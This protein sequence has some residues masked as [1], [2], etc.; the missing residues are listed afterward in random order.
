MFKE[1]FKYYKSK[2]PPPNL[3]EVIDFSNI[4]NAVDKVKRII[5]SNNNVPTKRFLE[6]GLKEANQWDVF[7]LDERPGLRFVRNPFLPIGQRY[8]IKRCLEN[9]TSKPNQLNLDTLGV[10][11]SDENWWTSCQSNNIQSSELLHKLRWATLGYHHN[12]N[13]KFLD[14]SLTFCISKQYIRCTVKILKTT[15]LKI[16]QS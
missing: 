1:K 8:W 6:V 5:I 2:S 15:F 12:W 9:Y 4:K 11:K 10:L 7:C 13:T 16:L 3:Q 14:P